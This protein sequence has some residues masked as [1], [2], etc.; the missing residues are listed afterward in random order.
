[1]GALLNLLIFWMLP[2]GTLFPFD[3]SSRY[4]ARSFS[5]S[6]QHASTFVLPYRFMRP[7]TS[8]G[9]YPLVVFL[10]GAGERGTDN[11]SQLKYLPEQMATAK[12]RK[13]HPCFLL[14][15]QCG[16]NSAWILEDQLTTTLALIEQSIREEPAIDRTRIYLTG[17]SM[18]GS[19]AWRL[20]ARRPELFAAV[21]PV[22]GIGDPGQAK[23]L[24]TVPI[25]A[26]HGSADSVILVNYSREMIAAM[27]SCGGQPH[28]TELLGVG[29][30]S[31]SYAYA[32]SSGIL[33]WMFQ[34][35]LTAHTSKTP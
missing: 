6:S 20:A 28:Y 32:E 10:H 18:G 25:W 9:K 27:R 4:E 26:V 31:W 33:D 30:N 12:T 14:A 5:D 22:C 34:Q 13:R 16:P 23:A 11:L 1:M 15:P 2:E 24:S 3:A 29:H 8:G 35:S 7:A 17:L 19:G 21:V